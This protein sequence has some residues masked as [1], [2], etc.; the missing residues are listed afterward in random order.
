VV[1]QSRIPETA[2]AGTPPPRPPSRAAAPKR[3]LLDP[4]ANDNAPTAAQR[5]LRAAIFVI[6]GSILAYL[7][8]ELLG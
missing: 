5:L 7:L 3:R 6:V 2:G 4:A 8:R 1:E